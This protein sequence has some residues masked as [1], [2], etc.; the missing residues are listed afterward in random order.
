[1]AAASYPDLRDRVV[2]VTGAGGGIGRAV[3]AAFGS[4]G[5]SVVLVGRTR[6]P[7]LAAADDVAAAGG[8][9]LVLCG[10]IAVEADVRGVVERV[11]DRFGRLDVLVN[12]AAAHQ[13]RARVVEMDLAVWERVLSVNLTGTML[14]AK[15]AA[16]RMAAVGSGA[17]VNIGS[18]SGHT[19]RLMNAAYAASK[20]AVAH[21]TRTLALELAADGV[22]VNAVSPGSTQTP[23]LQ[24]AVAR[25]GESGVAYRIAG[26]P[27]LFRSPIPLRRIGTPAEQAAPVLFLA[28]DASSYMTGQV[29]Q[30]DGGEGML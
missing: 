2:V 27:A 8:R 11:V 19:P 16:S 13:P 6:E 9:A 23:M 17:I 25:D 20:A 21:L 4:Q 18:L 12:N 30:V 3:A 1:V 29:L 5:S 26:D 7:L 24:Q 28:S 14:F 10:D 22:R 15:H